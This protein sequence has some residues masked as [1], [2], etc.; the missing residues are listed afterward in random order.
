MR[1]LFEGPRIDTLL[2]RVRDE[3]GAEA[4]IVS[5]DKVRSGGF[6]GFFTRERFVI[7]VLVE[8]SVDEVPQLPAAIERAVDAPGT[9]LELADAMDAAEAADA[10]VVMST[11][12]MPGSVRTVD[13][14]LSSAM[15][16]TARLAMVNPVLS[17]ESPSFAA[18]LAGWAVAA[19]A[20]TEPAAAAAYAA[21]TELV[22]ASPSAFLPPPNSAFV[23][24]SPS[25]IVSAAPSAFAPASPSAIVPAAASAFVPATLTHVCASPSGVDGLLGRRLLA[26]GVPAEIVDRVAAET[27]ASLRDR[28]ASALSEMLPPLPDLALEPGDVLV[29]A[30]AGAAAFDAAGAL[31]KRLK[32]DPN[33]VMLAA[34]TTLGTGVHAA[35]RLSGPAQAR[36]SSARLQR[37]DVATIVAVDAPCEENSAI[38]ARAVADALGARTVWALAEATSKPADLTDHLAGLGRLDGI[39]V[40]ATGAT[41]DPAT[42]LRPVMDLGLPTMLLEGR[43]G[44]PR[45]WANLIAERVQT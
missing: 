22:P 15:A 42:V 8:P 16:S 33:R 44:D 38:W 4:R 40:R 31:A 1:L 17:T 39:A 24:A 5:A 30:G 21:S 26:L 10:R 14:M 18:V 6:G 3:H 35:R 37:A 41:R 9:L 43:V 20:A 13:T 11:A 36:R 2:A 7:T 19:D 28:L 32:L 27:G 23:P 25:A 34:P 12:G 45:A 29:I